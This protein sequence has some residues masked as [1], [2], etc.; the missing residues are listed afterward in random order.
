[1]GLRIYN[2]VEAQNAHRQLSTTNN[3]LSRT[4]ERLSS[5]LRINRAADDAAGLAVSEEMRTQIRGMQV[6]SRCALDGVS[7][8]QVADGAL[9]GV[10]D[11]LQRVRDLAVQ[12]ANGT[13]TDLQRNNLDREVQ[14]V[15]SEIARVAADTEFNGI[16][17]LSGSVATAASAVTLQVGAN[18]SQVIAFTI[19]TMSASD[20]GVSGLAVSTAAS[21][22]A[23]IASLDAAIRAVNSQRAQMGAIQNRLEQ[24]IS[25]LELTSENLQAAE[26]RIRDADMA[27]EMIDYTRNQILQQ[28][29][30]AMLAQANQAPQSILQLLNG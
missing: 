24:T 15:I 11:M 17:I 22:T 12:A 7:L 30:T 23:A 14:S 1:M 21:A 2:N 20:L 4:M 8:V 25:R 9:G 6:A 10:S 5:G 18:G 28:S 16:K 27:S 3:N 13:L 19:G 29:G 26:S